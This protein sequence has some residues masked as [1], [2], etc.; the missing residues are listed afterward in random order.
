[1]V[2]TSEGASMIV[3]VTAYTVPGMSSAIGVPEMWTAEIEVAAVW[4]ASIDT[5]VPVAGVPVKRTVEIACCTECA[6]LPVEQD[7]AQIKVTTS[8][9]F[10]IEVCL[11][12]NTQEVV[13]VYFVGGFILIFGEIQLVSH[14]VGQEQG[15]LTGLLVA[16]CLC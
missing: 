12:L 15:L 7:I 8:P 4:I 14:L 9:V 2:S 11:R 3:A 10:T 13:E 16:H 1:M 5:E 6:I